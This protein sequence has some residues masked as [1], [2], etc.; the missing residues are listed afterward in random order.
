VCLD[1]SLL[2]KE[3]RGDSGTSYFINTNVG[4]ISKCQKLCVILNDFDKYPCKIL[5]KGKYS[6]RKSTFKVERV[7]SKEYKHV[8]DSTIPY[9]LPLK[10]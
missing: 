7:R 4:A 5:I 9:S 8:T 6:K 3:K 2:N 10:M 1:L